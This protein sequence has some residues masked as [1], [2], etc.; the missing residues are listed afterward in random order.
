MPRNHEVYGLRTWDN[1]F[2]LI[3]MHVINQIYDE[4]HTITNDSLKKDLRLIKSYTSAKYLEQV[5]Y[6]RLHERLE[7][8][9]YFRVDGGNYSFLYD[10]HELALLIREG[11]QIPNFARSF[12]KNLFSNLGWYNQFLITIMLSRRYDVT[13][14]EHEMRKLSQ[15]P[16]FDCDV[17]FIFDNK[18]IHCQIKDLAEH[19]RRERFDDVRDNIQDGMDNPYG[20]GKPRRKMAYRI[21]DFKGNPPSG[22][23]M[24]EWLEIGRS[25]NI[26]KRSFTIIIPANKYGSHERKI[27]RFRVHAFRHG[28]FTYSPRSD[29]SNLELLVNSYNQIED[30]ILNTSYGENDYFMLIANVVTHPR[31][32]A[33]DRREIRPS[34]LSVMT[35]ETFGSSLFHFSTLSTSRQLISLEKDFVSRVQESW[36]RIQ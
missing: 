6:S 35:V 13:R 10:L 7:Q 23:P 14:V 5:T 20:Y 4:S 31:W 3:D 21:V 12:R 9:R 34:R 18:T 22:M 24:G 33:D 1:V 19:T 29:F 27:I 32:L 17:E 2:S 26:R 36:I 28:S 16:R 11:E 8:L 25:L 15:G 30:R